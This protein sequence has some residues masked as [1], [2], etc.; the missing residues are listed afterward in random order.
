VGEEQWW[1][2]GFVQ[3]TRPLGFLHSTMVE[4]LDSL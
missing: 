2:H 4:F 3:A 1:F